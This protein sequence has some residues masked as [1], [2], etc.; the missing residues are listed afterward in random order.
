MSYYLIQQIERHRE[1]HGP[2]QHR[3]RLRPRRRAPRGTDVAQQR[4]RRRGEGRRPACCSASSAPRR[5]P[6]GWTASAVRDKR[7]FVVAGPDLVVDGER[8]PGWPLDRDPYHLETSI[9]GVFVAGDVRADSVKRVASRRRRGRDGRHP[10]APVP[11]EAMTNCERSDDTRQHADAVDGTSTIADPPTLQR[12]R[13]A[14]PVPVRE[15]HRR[16]ARLAV[17]ARAMSSTSSRARCTPRATRRPASTCCST[18]TLVLSRRVGADDV[19]TTRTSQRGVYAGAMRA[20]LGEQRAGDLQRQ[21]A[22]DRAV[23]VLRAGRPAVRPG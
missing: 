5:A 6:N 22:G 2:H 21:H 16:A 20:Y 4:D 19:E 9:P 8:P 15:A 17:R 12:R 3:D 18:G 13:T 23:P 14:H 1:H 7:G 11:G 10:G